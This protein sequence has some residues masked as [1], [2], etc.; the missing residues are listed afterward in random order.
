M[1]QTTRDG[2]NTGKGLEGIAG[3]RQHQRHGLADM[4]LH[5]LDERVHIDLADRHVVETGQFPDHLRCEN[6]LDN[7]V[8]PGCHRGEGADYRLPACLLY[9][10]DAADDEYNV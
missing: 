2:A 1:H 10:S 3:N 9:T 4:P 6:A 5:E 8:R 7:D